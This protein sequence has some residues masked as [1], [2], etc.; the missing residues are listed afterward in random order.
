M[1]GECEGWE[2]SVRGGRYGVRGGRYGVRGGRYGVRGGSACT[3]WLGVT[4]H[5]HTHTLLGR[6]RGE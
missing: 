4:F 3:Q 2:V 5:T 1:G 6:M